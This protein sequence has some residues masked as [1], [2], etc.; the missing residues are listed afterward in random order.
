MKFYHGSSEIGRNTANP[1]SVVRISVE[2]ANY[3]CYK[4]CVMMSQELLCHNDNGYHYI[5]EDSKRRLHCNPR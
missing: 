4:S 3:V 2:F 5:T 1:E